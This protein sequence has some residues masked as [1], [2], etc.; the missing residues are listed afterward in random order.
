MILAAG[1]FLTGFIV[2]ML[3][4]QVNIIALHRGMHKGRSSALSVGL[5]AAFADVVLLIAGMCGA[6][7]F[8]DHFHFWKPMKWVGA[9]V[10]F[11]SA[12]K[13][14][15]HKP[16][17]NVKEPHTKGR[18]LPGSFLMGLAVVMGNPAVILMWLMASGFLM[19]HFPETH[20]FPGLLLFPVAFLFGASA[21]FLFHA[22][23]VLKKIK[24][25]GEGSLHLLSRISAVALLGA[26]LFLILKKI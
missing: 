12:L 24:T 23:V 3:G 9:G 5:G 19:A 17:K 8:L 21:W 1:G 10:L 18:G 14:L 25:W 15:F 2:S 20:S 11:F 26:L 16:L 13:I 22:S 4:W 6:H 7:P